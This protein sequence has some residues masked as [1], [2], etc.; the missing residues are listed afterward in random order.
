RASHDLH[1]HPAVSHLVSIYHSTSAWPFSRHSPTLLPSLVSLPLLSLSLSLSLCHLFSSLSLSLS[2]SLSISCFLV[3]P[4][5]SLS[6][7]LCPPLFLLR[8]DSSSHYPSCQS[9][10]KKGEWNYW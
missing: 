2:L 1:S 6:L 9:F 8:A 7:S 3:Y 10:L 4:L 5:P